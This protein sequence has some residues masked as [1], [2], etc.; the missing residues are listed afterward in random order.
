MNV[1]LYVDADTVDR[2]A[3]K[4]RR[5]VQQVEH[6]IAI[7][8]VKDT[9]PYTP[10]LTGDMEKRTRVEGSTIIYPGPYAQYLYHGKVMVNRE[11]GKGP[12]HFV[13]EYGEDVIFYRKGTKLR[14]SDRDLVFTTSF[15]P[16]AQAY[17]LEASYAVNMQKWRR[18]G[19][20]EL[21]AAVGK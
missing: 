4:F 1:N 7:Q 9:K 21:V 12:S 3:L 18:M 15:H 13:N 16:D 2:L 6:T 19:A 20:D 17:W 14:A 5:S 8:I 11:T 10:F